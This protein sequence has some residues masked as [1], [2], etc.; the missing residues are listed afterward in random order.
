MRIR[1]IALI[2]SLSACR[3]SAEPPV[4]AEEILQRVA[5]ANQVMFG[6]QHYVTAGGIRRANVEG[7]TAYF[8]ETE[9]IVK[10]SGNVRVTF[11]DSEGDTTSVLT[12]KKGTYDW[13]TGDMTAEVDVVVVNP[14]EG[15]RI[16]TSV[17]YYD[18]TGDRIWSDKETRMIEADGTI[19][20]GTA[21]ESSSGMKEV[22]LTSARM[23][24]PGVQ[25]QS[26][27]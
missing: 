3:D 4:V 11:F 19:V 24:R 7:D 12:S 18:Q 16:E 26:T 9:G 5:D 6:V 20:E 10:I 13:N 8:L 14:R 1:W 15:R 27:Q 25:R 21:F 23:V 17:L 2:L 22:D